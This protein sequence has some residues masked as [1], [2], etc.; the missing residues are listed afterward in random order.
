MNDVHALRSPRRLPRA[1]AIAT[2]IA[3]LL[4]A[5]VP[6]APADANHG[7]CWM[8]VYK[9]WPVHNSDGNKIKARGAG[10]AACAAGTTAYLEVTLQRWSGW[11]WEEKDSTFVRL[12]DNGRS[13]FRTATYSGD[14]NALETCRYDASHVGDVGYIDDFCAD[15]SATR[16]AGTFRTITTFWARNEAGQLVHPHRS[17]ASDGRT[18]YC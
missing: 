5:L 13:G 3:A 16:K 18:I 11:R 12:G 17:R 2:A 14:R 4:V 9:P 6:A 8:R 10:E 15:G 1:F 7:T